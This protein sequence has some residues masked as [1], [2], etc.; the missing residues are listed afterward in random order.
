VSAFP[1]RGEDS[2][3]Y[4]RARAQP[5]SHFRRLK[6]CRRMADRPFLRPRT[7]ALRPIFKRFSLFGS[8][9]S[10]EPPTNTD[11][12]PLPLKTNNPSPSGR[13]HAKE[14]NMKQMTSMQRVVV[15]L[16]AG[17]FALTA[18]AEITG[19][20]LGI[21]SRAILTGT[22]AG[23][24]NPNYNRLTFFYPHAF[25]STPANN[26]YHGIGSYS[27]IGPV[28]SPT[29]VPTNSGFRI[30]EVYTGQSP[31]TLVLATN[32][33]H[34]GKLVS[35]TT[36]EHYSTMRLRPVHALTTNIT[37]SGGVPVTNHY[38]YGSGEWFMFN[39]SGGLRTQSMAGATITL[40]L[41][42][43]TPGLHLGDAATADLV[44]A[45]GDR[46]TLGD[47][48]Y[49]DFKPVFWTEA[50]APAGTYE[51]KFKL[52]DTTGPWLES[53]IVTIQFRVVDAPALTIRQYVHVQM[54][55]VT[56]GY[57][58]EGAPAADGPW[59]PV[60][61]APEEDHSG[62]G[63]SAIQLGTKTLDMPVVPGANQFFRLRKL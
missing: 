55:L 39:S 13:R 7:G 53:G 52:V 35:M 1:A 63:E 44:T 45:A 43:L 25:P 51:A 61:A 14:Q 6:F 28:A 24:P 9:W 33:T 2:P 21:D 49:F 32:G 17:A 41:V 3:E 18:R 4:A 40:E 36:A 23:Q 11:R 20:Y 27:L 47:G 58:L 34:A 48:G 19:F 31:L 16:A 30:P 10:P 62:T 22:Y 56:D 50:T 15:A 37:L 57:I 12:G 54:P 26:H 42:S 8:G 29:V 46:V 60:T 5:Y 59:T 38:G